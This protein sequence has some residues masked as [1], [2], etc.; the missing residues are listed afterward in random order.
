[1]FKNIYYYKPNLD[2]VVKRYKALYETSSPGHAIVYAMPAFV[3]KESVPKLNSLNLDIDMEMYLD[4]CLRNYRAFLELTRQI[5]DDLLPTFGPNFGIGDYSAFIKGE[6]V[7]TEDTS[8]A[9]PIL[10]ELSEMDQLELN[11][12]AYW[13]KMLERAM[14]HLVKQTADGPIA[15]VRGYYSPLDLAHALRGESLF[16]DFVDSPEEVHKLMAFCARAIVWIASRI[17]A[18]HGLIWEGNVAGAWL[19]PGTICMSEDIACLVSPKIYAAFARPYT[20]YVI[21]Q[22]GFGQIHTHSLGVRTIPEISKLNSLLGIQISDDPNTEP[23]FSQL[24][25]LLPRTNPIPLT[26]GCTPEQVYLKAQAILKEHNLTFAAS[27][28]S[29]EEG[30]TLINWVRNHSL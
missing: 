16:T 29:V 5:P 14:R 7:Y 12:D 30:Q 23:A 2:E 13:V 26:V 9:A 28:N 4:I 18:I 1:M 21:D 17:R 3:E 22:I 6:V 10:N 27:V 20:Q 25:F 19:K 24:D 8:W 15:L 11:S